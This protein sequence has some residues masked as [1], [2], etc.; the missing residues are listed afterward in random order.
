MENQDIS[1]VTNILKQIPLFENLDEVANQ[2]VIKH[3]TLQFYP[4][5]HIVFNE[6]DEGDAFYIIKN[7]IVRIYHPGEDEKDVAML[8]E[9]DYFGEMALI[10]DNPR[11]ATAKV[12]EDSEM[13]RLMK[14]DL[15]KLISEN[16]DFAA[17][18]SN[19]Y[20]N[21]YK[22]NDRLQRFN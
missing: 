10:S 20:L 17:K 12:E 13:F 4:H 8:G 16:E 18:I 2:E 6:G 5:K 1:I 3:I 19:T 21:R 14:A 9:N 11:N 15:I 22:K 7:G